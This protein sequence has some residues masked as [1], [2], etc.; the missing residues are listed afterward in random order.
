MYLRRTGD[1]GP[2]S[3]GGTKDP[4]RWG[5]ILGWDPGVGSWSGRLVG[6]NG[7]RP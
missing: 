7:V 4:G 1:E 5:K 6:D 3:W 2:R